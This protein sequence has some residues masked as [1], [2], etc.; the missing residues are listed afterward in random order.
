[1][2][3][4][5]H[6]KIEDLC[7]HFGG[8]KAVDNVNLSIMRGEVHALIGPNGAGKSSL[9]GMICGRIPATSGRI[10]FQGDDITRLSPHRRIRRGMAYS[11]QTVSVYPTLKNIENIR[12]AFGGRAFEGRASGNLASGGAFGRQGYDEA[13]GVLEQAGLGGRAE[14]LAGT[15]SHGHQRLLELAM[16]SSPEPELLV[17]DEPAQGFSAQGFSTQGFS[18]QDGSTRGLSAQEVSAQG[19]SPNSEAKSFIDLMRALAGNAT[20]LLIEH[21]MDIVMALADRVTV[22]NSGRVLTTGTVAQ[23]RA[24]KAVKQAYLGEDYAEN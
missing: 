10:I 8:L 22:L 4:M 18:A 24:N 9:A 17:L 5:T 20:I 16:A 23:V 15:M 19:G 13:L 2:A 12:L 6:L 7:C 1:M 3:D 21:N 11:F 14:E